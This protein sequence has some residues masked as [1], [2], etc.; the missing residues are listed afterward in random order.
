[1]FLASQT[2]TP[3][4]FEAQNEPDTSENSIGINEIKPGTSLLK[5]NHPP[6]S[7]MNIFLLK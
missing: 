7:S 3:A 1:M 4:E 2:D 6:D 5:K